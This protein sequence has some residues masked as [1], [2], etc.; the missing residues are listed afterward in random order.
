MT[1]PETPHID[2]LATAS[3]KFWKLVPL[4]GLALLIVY[5]PVSVVLEVNKALGELTVVAPQVTLAR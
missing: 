4:V 1:G 5:V 3:V 2:N